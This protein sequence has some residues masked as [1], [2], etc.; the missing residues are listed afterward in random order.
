MILLID[1]TY[2]T[3]RNALAALDAW[4]VIERKMR[5]RAHRCLI[6]TA[7]ELKGI[8]SLKPLADLNTTSALDA[9]LRI[10]NDSSGRAILLILGKTD[11]EWL[12][13]YTILYSKLLELTLVVLRAE[14]A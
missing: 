6:A 10:E 14:Q 11:L 9:L 3:M 13:S 12:L 4:A 1:S 7:D 5:S 2:R 8:Y